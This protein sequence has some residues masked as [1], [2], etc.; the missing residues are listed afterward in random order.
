MNNYYLNENRGRP[1]KVTAQELLDLLT[2]Y[3]YIT[4]NEAALI[5]ECSKETIRN[6]LRELRQDG[7]AII[8]GR[9]GLTLMSKKLLAED[10][11]AALELSQYVDWTIGLLKA[12]YRGGRPIRPLLPTMKRELT[13]QLSIDERKQLLKTCATYVVLLAH[14]DADEEMG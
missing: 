1:L 2:E 10:D 6:R 8:H 9:N 5:K 12:V 4:I 7:E 11:M 3:R 14:A 13:K